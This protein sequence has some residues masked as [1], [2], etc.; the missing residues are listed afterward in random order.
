MLSE[1]SG[2]TVDDKLKVYKMV[3][4][5]VPRAEIMNKSNIG[6]PTV[7]D[8]CK[9]ESNSKSIQIARCEMGISK[10]TKLTKTFK[11]GKFNKFD[12]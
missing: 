5:N 3:R 7:K 10:S 4:D 8:I 6:R 2:L 12:E 1:K 11:Q 9:C